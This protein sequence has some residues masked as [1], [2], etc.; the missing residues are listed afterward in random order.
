MNIHF[1]FTESIKAK[2][3]SRNRKKVITDLF[4]LS[5]NVS[6]SPSPSHPCEGEGGLTRD[7]HNVRLNPNPSPCN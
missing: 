1:N 3:K 4:F 7:K 5:H 2:A 6:I